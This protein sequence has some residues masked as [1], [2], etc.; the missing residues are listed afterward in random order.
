MKIIITLPVKVSPLF[1]FLILSVN[2][3]GQAIEKINFDLA[4]VPFSRYGAYTTLS[5]CDHYYKGTNELRLFEVTGKNMWKPNAVL[6]FNAANSD[7]VIPVTYKATPL[8]V[9]G[10]TSAGNLTFYYENTDVMHVLSNGPG[11]IMSGNFYSNNLLKVP[12]FDKTWKLIGESFV[13]TVKAG[14]VDFQ[15]KKYPGKFVVSPVNGKAEVIIEQF[16]SDW[17]PKQYHETYEQSI[18]KLTNELHQWVSKVPAINS[19]YTDAVNLALYINWACMI[20]PLGN[21]KHDGMVMS[22]NW[23]YNIW[24]WDNC[25]NAMSLSYTNPQKSWDQLMVFL[26]QQNAQGAIPDGITST[27]MV[28]EYKKPP[29]YGWVLS[30]LMQRYPLTQA[31]LTIIY[32]KLSDLT[33]YWFTYRDGNHNALAE[34]YHGNDSGWD[35]GTGFDFG[36]PAESPDL[37]TFL[38]KQMDEL[39][40]IAV[41]VGKADEAAMWRRRSDSTLA[42]MI[43][44]LWNGE[45]FV[46]KNVITGSINTQSQSL[47]SYIPLI[48]GKRLPP[49]IS[50]KMIADLKRPDYL[51]TPIGLASESPKSSLYIADG[52]WRGPVWGPSTLIIIDGLEALN[53]HIFAKELA[54][55]FCQNCIKNGFPENYD[56]LTGQPL[57]DPAYTW[58]SSVF[59][60]LC[61][62][63]FLR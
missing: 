37:S 42:N 49:Q 46:T 7:G 29:V 17:L 63:Y 15:D 33:N 39:A 2:V 3:F 52:Y 14:N 4:K 21:V 1:C 44:I 54:T 55:R 61:Y 53:E 20:K 8:S 48:L 23:M 57:R 19:T 59:L 13:I 31:Q 5:T 47:I 40:D 34:Y 26:D 25:F 9:E 24:A 51:L 56:A 18:L 6:Q 60:I 43:K 11:I 41:K 27:T 28:W 50:G 16:H 58:T 30:K 35:N 10:K 32:K 36:F 38:I 45:K 12:G 22:K 62:S